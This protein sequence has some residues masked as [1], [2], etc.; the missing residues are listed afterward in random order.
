MRFGGI[1]IFPLVSAVE[2]GAVVVQ[3]E[4]RTQGFDAPICRAYVPEELKAL[5]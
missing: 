2:A 3:P 1:T 5:I 4:G